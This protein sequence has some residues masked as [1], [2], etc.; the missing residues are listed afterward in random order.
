MEA[1]PGKCP[2]A[3]QLRRVREA[4]Q[5]QLGLN[6]DP[7]LVMRKGA[8]PKTTSGKVRR[9]E[10]RHRF[11]NGTLGTPVAV[12]GVVPGFAKD[13]NCIDAT[14]AEPPA[15]FPELLAAFGVEDMTKSLAENG[16]DSLRLTQLMT[17]AQALFDVKISPLAATYVP[18]AMLEHAGTGPSMPLPATVLRS[19]VAWRALR[20]PPKLSGQSKPRSHSPPTFETSA[21]ST[22]KSSSSPS[23][24]PSGATAPTNPGSDTAP[25]S[26][27]SCCSRQVWLQALGCCMTLVLACLCTAPA[28]W[29]Y[30][31]LQ[32]AIIRSSTVPTDP[33]VTTFDGG[34]G[35]ALMAAPLT[36][37]FAFTAVVIVAKWGLIG[38]YKAGSH[39]A[40][41]G[42][43]LRWWFVD[44]LMAMWETFV[45][46]HLLG[47]PWLNVV[48]KGLGCPQ[49]PWSAH[50]NRFI[51][52]VDLF[53][54]GHHS[55]VS[56]P[57]HCR[58]VT[59]V[60]LLMQP[61]YVHPH[62]QVEEFQVVYPGQVVRHNPAADNTM[63][64]GGLVQSEDRNSVQRAI[65]PFVALL[66]VALGV[67]VGSWAS[68]AVLGIDND[69]TTARLVACFFTMALTTACGSI[70]A[71]RV[72]RLSFLVDHTFALAMGFLGFWVDYTPL[73]TF[74][75]RA[76]GANVSITTQV[77]KCM[78]VVVPSTAYLVTAGPNTFL[79]SSHLRPKPGR[80]IHIERGALVG[81]S[82]V[83]QPG[84]HI[85]KGA[86]VGALAVV[87]AGTHVGQDTV[88]V[89][90]IPT[91]LDGSA[92][93]DDGVG[94]ESKA[95]LGTADG[96]GI[97]DTQGAQIPVMFSSRAAQSG[98]RVSG[99]T[100]LRTLGFHLLLR[101]LLQWLPAVGGF[102]LA[103]RVARSLE[104]ATSHV[105]LGVQVPIVACAV[106]VVAASV[107]VLMYMLAIRAASPCGSLVSS[108]G[109][110]LAT[111]G[112]TSPRVAAAGV[113]ACN[114]WMIGRYVQPFIGGSWVYNAVWA[115]AG[116][117]FASIFDTVLLDTLGV[118]DLPLIHLGHRVV[119][120]G[121]MVTGHRMERGALSVY[122]THIGSD[123]L[124]QDAY[125]M[126]GER[127]GSGVS[128]LGKSKIFG[129]EPVRAT[130][131]G[132][133]ATLVGVPACP[134]RLQP[135]EEEVASSSRSRRSRLQ[136]AVSWRSQSA[137]GMGSP[138]V[139]TSAS[140]RSQ[141]WWRHLSESSR[142]RSRGGPDNVRPATV[143]EVVV[144]VRV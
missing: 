68:V 3:A 48:Y 96:S 72:T 108:N 134:A 123:C 24:P 89:G 7:M 112:V 102:L 138:P 81:T 27:T 86:A 92:A 104:A 83:V 13:G 84:V 36:W 66:S 128:L 95:E 90:S 25:T 62:A 135:R 55:S 22:S 73:P 117:T 21:A 45:G 4:T 28:A 124:V 34:P 88:C 49:V 103:L 15:S 12:E 111:F 61:V 98:T 143:E 18:A 44:R 113:T 121:C 94:G 125:V 130:S 115:A 126:G 8:L 137:R 63:D 59:S 99:C 41:S 107:L 139:H 120:D 132:E 64:A 119:L 122:S 65:A 58:T 105:P 51:R 133:W 82:A 69:A 40:A 5:Q 110:P 6:L 106:L 93:N 131:C 56:G 78:G 52:E 141:R 71:C 47:T 11:F 80:P 37:M 9:R 91:N 32:D 10:C 30:V 127:L 142:Q 87:R 43:Y 23:P 33:W 35:L 1:R 114:S 76:M 20:Q 136:A 54:A 70:V 116:C 29:V 79:T 42:F 46:V 118:G 57:V 16:V 129:F 97:V 31:E 39:A 101:A 19:S 17:Q 67:W 77:N 109:R 53:H 140:T 50:L 75:C 74:V 100:M 2:T 144:S 60:G 26:R 38:R 85:G 14:T